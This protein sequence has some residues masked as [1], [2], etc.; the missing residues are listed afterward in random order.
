MFYSLP[1]CSFN[2]GPRAVITRSNHA[3]RYLFLNLKLFI[4][5]VFWH[6]WVALKDHFITHLR[7]YSERQRHRHGNNYFHY[8]DCSSA[9]FPHFPCTRYP[10][11]ILSYYRFPAVLWREPEILQNPAQRMP[12]R[13]HFSSNY[14]RRIQSPILFVGKFLVD[15]HSVGFCRP[16]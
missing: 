4:C 5:R 16:R 9:S 11:T 10:S 12:H 15:Q 7:L 6:P 13:Y 2:T 3:T 8:P 14:R 1:S